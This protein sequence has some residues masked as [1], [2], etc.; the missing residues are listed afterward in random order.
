MAE[1]QAKG[2]D[3]LSSHARFKLKVNVT[4]RSGNHLYP[5]VM[6]NRAGYEPLAQSDD[7][8]EEEE[9][10]VGL[11]QSEPRIPT[12]Q[13]RRRRPQIDLRTIDTAFKK[14]TESIAQK[15]KRKKVHFLDAILF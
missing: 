1:W 7:G 4:G 3:G 2:S 15:V 9:E 12:L 10:D 8:L 5:Q 11:R 14:W 13:R 6:V